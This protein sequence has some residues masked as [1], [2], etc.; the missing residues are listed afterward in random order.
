M[1][2][3]PKAFLLDTNVLLRFISQNDPLRQTTVDALAKLTSQSRQVFIC[4]QNMV[5]FRQVATRSATANGLG[6][7]SSKVAQL[8]TAIEGAFTLLPETPAI[9]PAWRALVETVQASGRANFD[10]RIV[11]IAQ[12]NGIPSVLTYEESS[13]SKYGNALGVAIVNPKDV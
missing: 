11:A 5:E 12:V 13:F 10:A 4:P 6:L 2:N 3:S 9:Y 8:M 1:P 7:D